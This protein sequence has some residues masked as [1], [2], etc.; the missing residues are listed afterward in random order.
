MTITE[1]QAIEEKGLVAK[2]SGY[3]Y[4]DKNGIDMVE[5]HVDSSYLFQDQ[6]NKETEFGGKLSVRLEQHECPLIIFGH[7]ECIFK[8][9]HV[10]K[11]AWLGP[12][13]KTVLIPKDDD[14]GVIISG[15]QSREFG[16][17]LDLTD[18]Q[19]K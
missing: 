14:Q 8:Q 4:T 7:D 3:K 15:F 16:Y 11:K 18:E 19:L 1:S 13:G 10:T 5:Y 6:M 17:G 12:N 9:F 2:N